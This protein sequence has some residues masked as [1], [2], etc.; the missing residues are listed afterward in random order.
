VAGGWLAGK[1]VPFLGKFLGPLFG[2]GAAEGAGEMTTVIGRVKDLQELRPGE[3]SLLE[4]L[5]N[6]G[7]PKTN[8]YQNAGVLRSEMKRGLAIRDAS[9]NDTNGVFLNAERNLLRDRG[10]TFDHTT[11]YW[12]PPKQ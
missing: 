10:W 7:N 12:I 6:V 1:V 9:P 4:R 5:P 8:W 2:R 11:N 3:Q